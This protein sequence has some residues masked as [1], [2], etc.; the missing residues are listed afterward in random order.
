MSDNIKQALKI[1]DL[2]IKVENMPKLRLETSDDLENLEP[3]TSKNLDMKPHQPRNPNRKQ[4]EK[5]LQKICKDGV[6][7][8][9]VV[10]SKLRPG[11]DPYSIKPKVDIIELG[12]R[13]KGFI[14]TTGGPYSQLTKWMRERTRVCVKLRAHSSTQEPNRLLTGAIVAF[15]KHWNLIMRDVDEVY[16]PAVKL[17]KVQASKNLNP[18]RTR[19]ELMDGRVMRRHLEC[20]F[21]MGNNVICVYYNDS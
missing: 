11:T 20:S 18:S 14:C 3:S 8:L 6:T 9:T 17:G 19:Y 12:N 10:K 13:E 21:V 5:S 15:D 16:I 1:E 7:P 2:K 4:R